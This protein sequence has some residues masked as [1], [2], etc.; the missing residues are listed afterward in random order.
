MMES[1]EVHQLDAALTV[2]ASRAA[3]LTGRIGAAQLQIAR[4]SVVVA[5]QDRKIAQL[6]R[7][8]ASLSKQAGSAPKAFGELE[9]LD[10]R[11]A[12]AVADRDATISNKPA[13]S[14][15]SAAVAA[16]RAAGALRSLIRK[17]GGKMRRTLL[18]RIEKRTS[19]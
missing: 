6:T 15:R 19:E 8:L 12:D 14:L 7:E 17:L 5:A 4:L 2:N 11:S 3:R 10:E 9:R 18:R 13:F 1:D 16:R